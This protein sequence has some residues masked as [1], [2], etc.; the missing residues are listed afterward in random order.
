LAFDVSSITEYR[1]VFLG[2]DRD[3]LKNK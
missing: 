2:L 3:G 1:R